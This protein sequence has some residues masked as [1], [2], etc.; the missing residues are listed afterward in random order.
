MDLMAK[1]QE[2]ANTGRAA[3]LCT[4]VETSG[5]TPRKAG[6]KMIVTA[7]GHTF[8]SVGG[9]MLERKVIGEALACIASGKTKLGSY[10][11]ESEGQSTAYGEAKIFIDPLPKKNKLYI[12]GAGHVG[13]AVAALATGFGFEVSLID[14]RETLLNQI[15][16]E[17]ITRH[18]LTWPEALEQLSFD[19]HTFVVVMT[20]SHESD[21]EITYACAERPHAYLGMIGSKKKVEEARSTFLKRGMDEAMINSIDMPIGMPIRCETPAEIAISIMARIIDTKNA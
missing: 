14:P 19:E 4:I 12:F 21:E 3:A 7:D 17:G 2:L 11:Q 16:T 10:S 18:C 6:S 20:H 8:G 15:I 13:Q 1:L 5:S 9:G